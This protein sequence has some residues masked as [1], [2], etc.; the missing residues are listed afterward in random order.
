MSVETLDLMWDILRIFLVMGVCFVILTPVNTLAL[1]MQRLRAFVFAAVVAVVAQLVIVVPLG[2]PVGPEA[3]AVAHAT[4]AVGMILLVAVGVF[5][6]GCRP[7]VAS[8][9]VAALPAIGLAVVFPLL[10]L[11]APDG[12]FA[13]ICFSVIGIGL[14]VGLGALLWPGVARPMLAAVLRR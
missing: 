11:V 5:G 8:A 2:P 3:V 13:S 6:R 4:I 10:G 7:A 12:W 9:V 14:Y 1:S